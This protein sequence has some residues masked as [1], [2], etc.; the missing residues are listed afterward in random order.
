MYAGDFETAIREQEEVLRLN[1]RFVLAYVS[2]ALSQ[3]AQGHPDLAADTYRKVA[4]I[5]AR[6]ASVA[7]S[8]LA[9]IALYQGRPGDAV[10]ILQKGIEA[11]LANQDSNA[12]AEKLLA[13]AD[14]H[15]ELREPAAAVADAERAL[16]MGK[17]ENILY[18]AARLYLATGREARAL[19]LASQLATRL[20]PD[21]QAYA[22]LIRGEAELARGKH[23]AAISHYRAAK[24][25]ADTWAG[26]LDLGKAYLE[27][28]AFTEADTELETCV[29]RRG[30]ATALF[31]E[32]SPTYRLFP[33]VYY[34]LG[35]AREGLKSPGATDAYKSFLAVRTGPANA[36]VADA[37]KRLEKK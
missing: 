13:L 20:E 22:E 19:A 5:D 2:K 27:A 15:L 21:P 8:G 16:S 11:D 23:A 9:D 3:L 25:I 30:E 24:K 17:G 26:R 31:L 35:R 10:P 37:R 32:E 6:G 4:T 33:P 28:G 36:L 29:K 18:P 12:A 1:P 14:A 34:Y 7:V